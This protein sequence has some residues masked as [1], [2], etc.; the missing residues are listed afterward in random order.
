[1]MRSKRLDALEPLTYAMISWRQEADA[2]L[3]MYV[4]DESERHM[5]KLYV[6]DSIA[7]DADSQSQSHKHVLLAHTKVENTQRN[8][9]VW[10]NAGVLMRSRIQK[11]DCQYNMRG[12]LLKHFDEA[13]GGENCISARVGKPDERTVGLQARSY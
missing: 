9:I 10:Y 6:M 13:W 3:E 4:T 11:L 8:N 7:L 2:I 5:I 12:E 1:M